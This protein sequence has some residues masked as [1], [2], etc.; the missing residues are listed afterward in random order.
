MLACL[1]WLAHFAFMFFCEF[2]AFVASSFVF[3]PWL[4]LVLGFNIFMLHC[5][6]G[7]LRLSWVFSLVYPFIVVQ[8]AFHFYLTFF[9]SFVLALGLTW[10]V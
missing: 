4:L 10:L 2:L 8:R 1:A 7:A 9:L 3:L 6:L 5:I